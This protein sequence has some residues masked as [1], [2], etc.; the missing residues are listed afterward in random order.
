MLKIAI[1]GFGR[2]GRMALRAAQLRDDLEVVAINDLL[3]PEH[4]S[5]LLRYDSVHG[6]LA[7]PVE[8]KGDR[9]LVDQRP[10]R[11][12]QSRAPEGCDWGSLGVNVV[13]E[14][15][16]IFLTQE[17]ARGHLEAGAPKVVLSAPASDD[18]PTFVYGVNTDAYRGQTI[19]SAA[20]CTT[21]CLAPIAKVL[22]ARYGLKR[23]L[24]TTVHATTATQKVVDGPAA[25]DWRF[26][27]GIL[28]NI[29][30]ASTGAAKAVTKVL[31]ELKGRLTGMSF[32]VPVSD[33]SVVDLTCELE[34]PA[35]YEAIC[36]AM[37]EESQGALRGVLGYTDEEVVSTD[38]RGEACTSVFDAKAGIQLDPTFVKVV[39]WYDNEWGYASKLVDL[40]QVMATRA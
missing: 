32:R 34:Q 31:P 17:K 38:L 10:I 2:I 26:G 6:R 19:I 7:Q 36:A 20:S 21:N 39:A 22:H 35:S 30:P 9:L 33:V 27:R 8:V 1:N 14:S 18:T 12:S 23:G 4:L 11:L 40:A 15:T 13:I 3:E 37:K 16:G 25:K 29:I 24:M 5:Y 28:E